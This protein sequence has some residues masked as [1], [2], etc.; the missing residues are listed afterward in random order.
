MTYQSVETSANAGEP[1]ELYRFSLGITRWTFTSGQAAVVHQAE[2]YAPVTISRGTIEQGSA[3]NR[4]ALEVSIVRDNDVATE[5][6]SA[7]PEGVMALT[8]YRKH[9][10]DAEVVVIF[11]GRVMSARWAGS[12]VSLQ[13]EPIATSLARVGLRARYQI[14]CRHPLYS[15][16]CG[17]AKELHRTD[18]TVASV[19][20]LTVTVGTASSRPDGYFMGGIIYT[21]FGNRMIVAHLGTLLTLGAPIIGL[22]A[23]QIVR[24]YAG[25]SHLTPD[26][27]TKFANL[28]NYGGF[29]YIPRKNPF[30]GDAIA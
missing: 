22:A 4:A 19:S 1:Q 6:V 24:M 16:G 15:V 29:P 8:I 12:G 13:V 20:G 30:A 26:C 14:G 21:D 10:S 17:V 25:C 27:L 18:G 5:F 7:A 11:K 3:I 9:A 2:I 23:A 28:D